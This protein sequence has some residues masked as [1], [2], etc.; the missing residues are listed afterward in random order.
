MTAIK[1]I[2]II[3]CGTIGQKVAVELDK[4]SVPGASLRA[5][6]SR[7]LDKVRVFAGTLGSPPAVVELKDLV[8]MV[9]LVVEAAPAG[10]D[11]LAGGG[12]D[13][14]TEIILL[15]VFVLVV[16]AAGTI[17]FIVRRQTRRT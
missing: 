15:V 7:N 6:S 11:G 17:I 1:K 5:M 8:P 12:G 3:G 9:D 10:G 2:G 14:T 4:G 16:I 13:D